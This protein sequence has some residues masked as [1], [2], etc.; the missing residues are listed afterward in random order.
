[1]FHFESGMPRLDIAQQD[2]DILAHTRRFGEMNEFLSGQVAW[3]EPAFPGKRVIASAHQVERIVAEDPRLELEEIRAR[4]RQHQIGLALAQQ[5]QALIGQG[6]VQGH[7]HAREQASVRRDH[8]GEGARRQRRQRRDRVPSAPPRDV[9]GHVV[10]C[11]FEVGDQRARHFGKQFAF[12]RQ[13]DLARMRAPAT[14]AISRIFPL[15]RRTRRTIR[16]WNRMSPPSGSRRISPTASEGG[17]DL[18]CHRSE[19]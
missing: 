10:E 16:G 11:R 8:G 17:K 2:V 19:R 4:R 6:V 7:D 13:R 14:R 9:I 15:S 5:R 1:V 3:P 12:R 18:P